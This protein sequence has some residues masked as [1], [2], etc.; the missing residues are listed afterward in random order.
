MK[1]RLVVAP[2]SRASATADG[3]PTADMETYYENFAKGGF[4][5]IIT[6]GVYPD[7]QY[8]SE[9]AHQPGMVNGSHEAAWK[10]VA[11][12]IKA[13]GSIPIMQI[14]HAGALSQYHKKTIA[15]SV[16]IPIGRTLQ[17]YDGPR[18]YPTP[19]R[20]MTQGDIDDV[21]GQFAAA[22][23]R[24]EQSGFDGVEVHAMGIY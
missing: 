10:K 17:V 6:E 20:A 2:M 13:H 16:V 3:T 1:N 8:G 23:L 24:A 15:P 9:Y 11:E 5:L 4:G 18:T 21:I 22:A 12:K 19:S 14:M 7:E